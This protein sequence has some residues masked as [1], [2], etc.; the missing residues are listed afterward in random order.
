MAYLNKDLNTFDPQH[1]GTYNPGELQIFYDNRTFAGFEDNL[2]LY[3]KY[4]LAALYKLGRI[5]VQAPTNLIPGY[6]RVI[7]YTVSRSPLDCGPL[8]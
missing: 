8:S 4:K 6:L 5:D 2:P 3:L 7:F 1:V